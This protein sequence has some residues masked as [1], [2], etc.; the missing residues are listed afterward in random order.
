MAPRRQSSPFMRLVLCCVLTVA[1]TSA[2]AQSLSEQITVNVVEV[3]V[4]VSR[5]GVSVSGLT[6]DDFV[7]TVDGKPQAIEYFDV[8]QNVERTREE[9]VLEKA[10]AT[11]LTRRRMVVLLFDLSESSF[12]AIRRA[13]KAADEYVAA[14]PRGDVFAVATLTNAGVTFVVPFLSDRVAVRRAV[15]TLR[16]SSASD[17]FGVATMATERAMIVD[18]AQPPPTPIH[19]D[20][21]AREPIT[22]AGDEPIGNVSIAGSRGAERDREMVAMSIQATEQ[23]RATFRD[24]VMLHLGYLADRLAPLN[25]IKHVI[26]LAENF[27][28]PIEGM[29]E[30]RSVRQRF[31]DAGVVLD[32]VDTSNLNAPWNIEDGDR[33]VT[34]PSRMHTLALETGGTVARNLPQLRE[35]QRTTYLL[36]FR[37]PSQRGRVDV[38]VKNQ[39]R[40]TDVRH[41]ETYVIPSNEVRGNDGL[42]LAD[43]LMNDIPQ[44]GVSVDLDVQASKSEQSVITATIPGKELLALGEYSVPVEMFLYIFDAKGQAAEWAR[45]KARLDLVRGRDALTSS[46][47]TITSRVRL[48]PGHY[49]AKVVL[50]AGDAQ[51]T[52]FARTE[53]TIP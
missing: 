25:G 34:A 1:A 15:A 39:P 35:R 29:N 36:G 46:P 51:A 27:T 19:E 16:G 42:L 48:A 13:Q 26:L 41:R 33:A 32:G 5:S 45:Y 24:S 50:R 18:A 31:R 7:L 53:L 12:V 17:A 2:G 4:Y 28:L 9:G 10:D 20:S 21:W 11:D 38:R 49:I 22:G 37:P 14:A 6:K 43:V 3:P 40:F 44:N 30:V 52:G 8:I 23:A 47:Y